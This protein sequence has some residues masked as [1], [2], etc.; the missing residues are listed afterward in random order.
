MK[1]D[2]GANGANEMIFLP[3]GGVEEIGMNVSMYGYGTPGKRKWLVVDLGIT[4]P[5]AQ[6]APGIDLMFPDIS[7]LK[8]EQ[9]NIVGI[10]IT[11]AHEDHFGALLDL[12]SEIPVPVYMT[13][14][15]A[16]LLRAK[17]EEEHH[18]PEI[19]VK[20]FKA[21]DSI[22]LSP[23]TVEAI[24]VAHSIPES[25]ALAISSP[26]G[27]VV[28]TGDWKL[29]P[30]PLLGESTNLPRLREI[31]DDG[32]L[33]L[34]CD[35]TNITQAGRS[36]TSCELTECLTSL[37]EEAS[38]RVAV[39]TFASNVERIKIMAEIAKKTG[40]KIVV[41]GRAMKRSIK[42]A[43]GLGMLDGVQEFLYE[44][45]YNTIPRDKI[46]ALMTGSQGEERAALSVIS[47]KGHKRVSFSAG[48]T[49]IFSSHTIPGN[50][51]KVS[52]VINRLADQDVHVITDQDVPLV[53]VSGH[54]KCD[55]IKEMY[56]AV[57]P[58]ILIPVHGEPLHIKAHTEFA[59]R[60]GIPEVV[61][62]RNGTIARLAPGKAEAIDSVFVGRFFKDG[63]LLISSSDD[64]VGERQKLSVVGVVT[65]GVVLNRKGNLLVEPNVVLRGIP[66]A[67][68]EGDSF[69]EICLDA[70]IITVDSLPAVHSRD[71]ESVSSSVK[72]AV[73]GA[74][75]RR[76]GKKP[77]VDVM[78][79]IV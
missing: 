33:A 71:S 11:H 22:S 2:N 69:E 21:G 53:H 26:L 34:V 59:C 28:H 10:V 12:W 7:F 61:R 39:T 4:F 60:H 57:R 27:T 13:K 31:G 8:K 19:N 48:D 63:R 35:S 18:P 42:V 64:C 62:C 58:K 37:V 41:L 16:E 43:S 38:G 1:E 52:S 32:V 49:V 3:I 17:A 9:A 5:D 20:V 55:E 76:W 70:V 75:A 14:F 15:A 73:E 72:R 68:A 24:E 51:D 47:T 77:V 40:R 46:I 65:V 54:P 67:D 74:V 30:S 23:F 66:S 25:V 56:E 79:S 78:V 45:A 29:G 50:E 6:K 36:R 44:E